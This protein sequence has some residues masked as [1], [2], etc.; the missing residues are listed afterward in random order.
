MNHDH[1]SSD[2]NQ[3]L[4]IFNKKQIIKTEILNLPRPTDGPDVL[5]VR[6]LFP[7]GCT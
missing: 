6:L 3:P 5:A 1:H 2:H 4:Q 7:F